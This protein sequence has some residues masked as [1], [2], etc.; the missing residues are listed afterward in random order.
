M[1]EIV[2]SAKLSL[3]M[4]QMGYK[5]EPIVDIHALC[6]EPS[7]KLYRDLF[8]L[9]LDLAELGYPLLESCEL[10]EAKRIFQKVGVRSPEIIFILSSHCALAA[11]FAIGIQRICPTVAKFYVFH[12]NQ[13]VFTELYAPS[14]LLITESL[15]ANLKGVEYGIPPWKM[16]YLPHHFPKNIDQIKPDRKYLEEFALK[17]KKEVS[18][19][20]L[21]IGMVSRLGI[22]KNCSYVFDAVSKL[23]QEG[24]DILL[25]VKGNFDGEQPL[26]KTRMEPYLNEPWFLW[27][28]SY[29][30]FP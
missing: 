9:N 11:L 15:L 25:V 8:R 1:G 14:D 26:W 3:L 7:N 19:N 27:D 20:T 10:E 12:K 18:D 5:V 13:E 22:C 29:T 30:H 6:G 28:K 21:V 2:N 24:L 23:V 4:Q 17:R 16:I